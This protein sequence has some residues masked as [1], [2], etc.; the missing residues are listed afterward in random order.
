V[1]VGKDLMQPRGGH[2]LQA[3]CCPEADDKHLPHE[4]KS[5]R[6]RARCP[7]VSPSFGVSLLRLAIPRP[8]LTRGC[9]RESVFRAPLVCGERF[10]RLPPM[11][12]LAIG[13]VAV[14]PA[15]ACLKPMEEIKG[16]G[17]VFPW[18]GRAPLWEQCSGGSL[19]CEGT[20]P[21]PLPSSCGQVLREEGAGAAL[22]GGQN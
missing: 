19:Q 3:L 2:T 10:L 22:R 1:L 4:L 18:Q 12:P 6:Q 21:L 13:R 8:E 11:V 7:S 15:P 5:F 17:G 20:L 16:G 14:P 9:C